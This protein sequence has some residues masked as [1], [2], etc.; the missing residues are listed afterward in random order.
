MKIQKYNQFNEALQQNGYWNK[1]QLQKEANKY[2]TRSEF[3][4]NNAYAYYKSL[5]M[6]ILDELFKNHINNGYSD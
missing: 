5:K 3:V 1:E 2:K 6:N 4:K